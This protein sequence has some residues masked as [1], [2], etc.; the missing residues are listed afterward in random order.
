MQPCPARARGFAGSWRGERKLRNCARVNN[1]THLR[2][3]R[4]NEQPQCADDHL[5]AYGPDFK[6]KV[7]WKGF[8]NDYSDRLD[9]GFLEAIRRDAYAIHSRW[10]ER[11]RVIA[12]IVGFDFS[13]FCGGEA[14]DG[15]FSSDDA[16]AVRVFD[17][18]TD[19]ACSL[20]L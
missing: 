11:H 13:L 16:G 9:I 6:I 7:E 10:K 3:L 18:P 4:S 14:Y 2:A 1:A 5:L 12:S 17:R 20:T 8:G 19:A 15:Y